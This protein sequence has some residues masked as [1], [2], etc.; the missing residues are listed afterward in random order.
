MTKDVQTAEYNTYTKSTT[1]GLS[2]DRGAGK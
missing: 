1:T 2:A